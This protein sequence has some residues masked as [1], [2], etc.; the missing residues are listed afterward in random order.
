[1]SVGWCTP[2]SGPPCRPGRRWWWRTRPTWPPSPSRYGSVSGG[3]LAAGIGNLVSVYDP[4]VVVLG[5]FLSEVFVDELVV[6]RRDIDD[7]L[8]GG[9]GYTDLR[10]QTSSVEDKLGSRS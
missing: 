8:M 1:M 3:H 4:E 6:L 9:G 2:P 7:W 10:L 5:G